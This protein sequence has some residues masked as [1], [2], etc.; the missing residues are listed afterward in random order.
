MMQDTQ[1]TTDRHEQ[2]LD[3]APDTREPIT[4]TNDIDLDDTTGEGLSVEPAGPGSRRAAG[5]DSGDDPDPEDGATGSNDEGGGLSTADT[6]AVVPRSLTAL[7]QILAA[8]ASVA[9]SLR[10]ASNGEGEPTISSHSAAGKAAEIE[11]LIADGKVDQAMTLVHRIIRGK[12]RRAMQPGKR[13]AQADKPR[14]PYY[15]LAGAWREQWSG[16]DI[17]AITQ[18]LAKGVHKGD[19]SGTEVLEACRKLVTAILSDEPDLTRA[20]DRIARA[21]RTKEIKRNDANRKSLCDGLTEIQVQ[22]AELL[23]ADPHEWVHPVSATSTAADDAE[24][25][26]PVGNRA[27]AEPTSITKLPG[28]T[29]AAGA[30]VHTASQNGSVVS[31][32]A[33]LS[34]QS[35]SADAVAAP[36]GGDVELEATQPDA[37][38]PEVNT[39][40][41]QLS[42]GTPDEADALAELAS[43]HEMEEVRHG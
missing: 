8:E 32:T 3:D 11:Q 24:P 27:T 21:I 37:P 4:D 5:D 14:D 35:Q 12:A 42:N 36:N 6:G 2:A 39:A 15:F 33:I 20:A 22:V 16:Q 26:G 31:G 29:D 43:H 34:E 17:I 18:T 23:G 10:A 28:T 1:Q 9:E 40:E 13:V 25:T 19:T 38:V 41:L 7:P 30:L